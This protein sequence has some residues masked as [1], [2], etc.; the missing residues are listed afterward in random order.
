MKIKEL[1]NKQ[2]CELTK[3]ITT[4]CPE[5]TKEALYNLWN[6]KIP[7]PETNNIQRQ[8]YYDLLQ[9]MAEIKATDQYILRTAP[10]KLLEDL[11]QKE[12]E[13]IREII[14]A[15]LAEIFFNLYKKKTVWI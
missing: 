2:L 4:I 3:K 10:E 7:K 6:N 11:S 1:N 15:E 8:Q 9:E 5:Y 13:E 12:T 14:R